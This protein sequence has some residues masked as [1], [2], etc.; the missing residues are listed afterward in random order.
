MPLLFLPMG[1]SIPNLMVIAVHNVSKPAI[2]RR[3][4]WATLILLLLTV[5]LAYQMTLTRSR[6]SPAQWGISF[7]APK[8]FTRRIPAVPSRFIPF[9]SSATSGVKAT[10]VVWQLGD[11]GEPNPAKIPAM[12]IRQIED[13]PERPGPGDQ[14]SHPIRKMLGPVEGAEQVSPLGT[15]LVRT[16]IFDRRGVYAISLS[17]ESGGRINQKLYDIF[18]Q[19]CQSV[20]PR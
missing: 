15:S 4:L 1:A 17:V 19:M 11:L 2:G 7:I 5:A 13:V 10:V 18:D 12:V 16:A 8:G 20:Q 6:I 9:V 14:Q 3:A